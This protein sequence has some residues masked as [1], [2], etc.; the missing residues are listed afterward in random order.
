MSSSAR[1]WA[2]FRKGT[3]TPANPPMPRQITQRFTLPETTRGT[4]E[5][6]SRPADTRQTQNVPSYKR[7]LMLY[8]L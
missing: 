7:L 8:L 3:Q 1:I 5:G 2:G 6:P 4:A